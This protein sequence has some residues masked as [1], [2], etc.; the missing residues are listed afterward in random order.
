MKTQIDNLFFERRL[1]EDGFKFIAG[2][3]EAG[4]GPWAGDVYAAFVILNPEF[5][6]EGLNDSKKLTAKKREI[7]SEEIKSRALAYSIASASPEEIDKLNILEATRLA[8]KRAFEGLHITPDYVLLDFIQ[9]PWL[10]TPHEALVKGDSLSASISAASI[11]AKVARDKEMESMALKYP[12]Y[13]FDKH[14]GYGTALH[15]EMLLKYGPCEIHR[16]SFK[17]VK[18]LLQEPFES[19]SKDSSFKI[20][21]NKFPQQNSLF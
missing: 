4:R 10:Q 2:G 18:E 21:L 14:K 7:L 1:R 3:D 12:E 19:V 15:K 17:P 20:P 11:L 16:K 9:L 8:F 6:L 5:Y 13:A